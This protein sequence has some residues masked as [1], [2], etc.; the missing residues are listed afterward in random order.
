MKSELKDQQNLDTLNTDDIYSVMKEVL[1][2]EEEVD[3]K[4]E[5]F[6]MIGLD[7]DSRLQYFELI[8]TGNV[9]ATSIKPMEIFRWAVMKGSANVILVRY[10]AGGSLDPTESDRDV[11]DRLLQVGRILNIK[12]IDFMLI[13]EKTFKSFAVTGLLA[14]IEKSTKWVPRFDLIERTRK[15]GER[16]VEET[17]N[18][19]KGKILSGRNIEIAKK[20]KS[21]NESIEKIMKYSGLSKEEIEQ[22]KID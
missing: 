1:L 11:T 20:M 12:V 17:I 5:Y 21:E 6:W 4:K 19:E 10:H 7:E 9:K 15:E 16:I 18:R 8:S 2:H 3:P 13:S 22:L 14:E